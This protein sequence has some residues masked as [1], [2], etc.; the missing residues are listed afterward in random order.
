VC[1]DSVLKTNAEFCFTYIL[2]K[3]HVRIM[4]IG[5]DMAVNGQVLAKVDVLSI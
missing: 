4:E 5:L 3:K 2:T 1:E